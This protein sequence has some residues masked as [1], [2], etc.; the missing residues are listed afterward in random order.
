MVLHYFVMLHFSAQVAPGLRRMLAK[1]YVRYIPLTLAGV[2]AAII[3][4]YLVSGLGIPILR[5]LIVWGCVG[6]ATLAVVILFRR[7]FAD[8]LSL[9]GSIL[10]RPTAP[11]TTTPEPGELSQ[12]DAADQ[13]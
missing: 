12:P 13:D 5:F 9:V 7:R 3:A 2:A 10:R 11:V 8:E 4:V 6:I 1:A